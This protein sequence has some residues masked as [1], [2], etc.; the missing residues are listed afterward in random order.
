MLIK[1]SALKFG[2]YKNK[3]ET[4]ILKWNLQILGE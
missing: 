1:H 3:I 2:Q 4:S